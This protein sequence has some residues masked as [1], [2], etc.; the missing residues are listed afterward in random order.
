[1]KLRV[2]RGFLVPTTIARAPF[3]GDEEVALLSKNL[4]SPYRPKIRV[5]RAHCSFFQVR[6]RERRFACLFGVAG[7]ILLFAQG[8]TM[9]GELS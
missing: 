7:I 2:T 1:M 4:G 5:C 9:R 6:R 8:S 3:R